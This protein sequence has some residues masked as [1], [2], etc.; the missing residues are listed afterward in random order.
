MNG[1][2]MTKNIIKNISDIFIHPYEIIIIDDFS[3]DETT[4]LK[5]D[6]RVRYYRNEEWLGV[7][8]SWN[9]WISKA[10]GDYILVINNDIILKPWFDTAMVESLEDSYIV[11]PYSTRLDK[12]F[13]WQIIIKQQN[14][15][16]WCWMTTKE[17]RKEIGDIDESLIIWYGDDRI[18]QRVVKDLKQSPWIANTLIHH[19]ES[20]TLMD[21]EFKH[22]VWKKIEEDKLRWQEIIKE[23]GWN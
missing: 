11:W 23:R 3:N 21:N 16:G 8:K 2:D 17:R 19:Y 18:F 13:E 20:K 12:P 6:K 1:Y 4:E 5:N 9:K 15:I 10:K 22:K 14:I 7:N